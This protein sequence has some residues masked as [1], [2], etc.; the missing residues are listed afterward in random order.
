MS[1]TNPWWLYVLHSIN[2][3]EI[4]SVWKIFSIIANQPL[5]YIYETIRDDSLQPCNEYNIK[6]NETKSF[7]V[8]Q[9][10]LAFLTRKIYKINRDWFSYKSFFFL[11]YIPVCVYVIQAKSIFRS[12][13]LNISEILMIKKLF[14]H[15][16][17]ISPIV[18]S[19]SNWIL[20]LF[21]EL[22]FFCSGCK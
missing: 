5:T 8:S 10:S 9:H 14:S 11:T 19:F 2:K 13:N 15:T 4:R 20:L 3:L 1:I 22:L 21:F 16:R 18:S 6:K 17:F 7:F 12:R